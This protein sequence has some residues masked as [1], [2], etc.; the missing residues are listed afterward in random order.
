[1]NENW[2]NFDVDQGDDGSGGGEGDSQQEPDQYEDEYAQEEEKAPES[3]GGG[4]QVHWM[5]WSELMLCTAIHFITGFVL[6]IASSGQKS[7]IEFLRLLTKN[8][9]IWI[10]SF[11]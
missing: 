2:N 10:L 1:M 4:E 11:G 3:G 8:S 7:I 6:S 5:M 9:I